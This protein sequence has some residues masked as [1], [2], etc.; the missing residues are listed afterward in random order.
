MKSIWI[1]KLPPC[2]CGTK[3]LPIGLQQILVLFGH[4]FVQMVLYCCGM[5]CI[6]IYVLLHI[7]YIYIYILHIYFIHIYIYITYIFHIYYIYMYIYICIYYIYISYIYIYITYIYILHIYFIYITYTCI[8]ICIY[9]IYILHI[10]IYILHIYI[11]YI[12]L[13]QISTI[14]RFSR[15]PSTGVCNDSIASAEH[16]AAGPTS[17][18]ISSGFH[19]DSMQWDVP[20]SKLTRVCAHIYICIYIYVYIYIYKW[21]IYI[22]Y[23]IYREKIGF[24]AHDLEMVGLSVS[25]RVIF[26]LTACWARFGCPGFIEKWIEMIEIST[27]KW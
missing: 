15:L 7:Y 1:C 19:M 26:R 2:T 14:S 8:Y 24:P 27:S 17:L 20:F 16:G 5:F 11:Y 23:K 12:K 10:Y 6:Y 3:R 25:W 21:Y 13:G 9:Y 22:W 4:R 18:G